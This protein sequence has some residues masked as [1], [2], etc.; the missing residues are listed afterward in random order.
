MLLGEA[1]GI[2]LNKTGENGTYCL[3]RMTREGMVFFFFHRELCQSGSRRHLA[4][5]EN[6]LCSVGE[7]KAIRKDRIED[8]SLN[9]RQVG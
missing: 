2:T 9:Y 5:I 8:R 4:S 6:R 3:E 1:S 7:K